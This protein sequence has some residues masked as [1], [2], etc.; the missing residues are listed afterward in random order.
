MP[1]KSMTSGLWLPREVQ[2]ET[3]F[4]AQTPIRA[5]Q[6]EEVGMLKLRAIG[7][8]ETTAIIEFELLVG[9]ITDLIRGRAVLVAGE[10]VV[11]ILAQ[12]GYPGYLL[13]IV[14]TW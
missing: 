4:R 13:T 14:G 5:R 12:L 7:Y 3:T 11:D 6:A 2:V 1:D 10:P 9:G 8:W